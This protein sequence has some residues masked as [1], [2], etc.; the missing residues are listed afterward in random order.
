MPDLVLIVEGHG[1]VVAMPHVV[2]KIGASCGLP[3]YTSRPIRSRGWG[4]IKKAGGLEGFVQ[5]AASRHGCERVLIVV[6][7]DDGCPVT[8]RG[9]L[10][11][12]IDKLHERYGVSIEICFCIR[13]FE[14]WLLASLEELPE[15]DL[16]PGLDLPI[17]RHD[18]IRD[19]KGSLRKFLED[20]YSETADQ[21][22]LAKR[23]DPSKLYQRDRSFRRF[24]K[25][26]TGIEY[27]DLD[28]ML[29][30]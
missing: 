29:A 24:V 16:K 3:L 15:S 12:R 9:L 13:E 11:G 28:L 5:L 7:L 1:D 22:E 19:A 27:P 23:I 25:A 21:G 2:A 4:S 10:A 17:E 30:L 6:D 14:A 20:G 18:L 26:T 8:E